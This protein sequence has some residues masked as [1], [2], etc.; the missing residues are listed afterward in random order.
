MLFHQE[1]KYDILLLLLHLMH[2]L[3]HNLLLIH[4]TRYY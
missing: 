3:L 4:L 1:M 2:N